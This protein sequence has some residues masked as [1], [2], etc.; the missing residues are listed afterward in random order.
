MMKSGETLSKN[1]NLLDW[2]LQQ[3]ANSNSK[4]NKTQ[5]I[6]SQNEVPIHTH[7]STDFFSEI[8]LLCNKN[9]KK[10]SQIQHISL[11]KIN[12]AVDKAFAYYPVSTVPLLRANIPHSPLI[13]VSVWRV[14]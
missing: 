10:S 8:Q 5:R 4:N 9:R 13:F 2:S 1:D 12:E 7:S 3:I 11:R 14:Y 6:D